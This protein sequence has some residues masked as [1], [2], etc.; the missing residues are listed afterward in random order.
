MKMYRINGLRIPA[1][2]EWRIIGAKVEEQGC[3][4][5]MQSS[6]SGMFEMMTSPGYWKWQSS[7]YDHGLYVDNEKTLKNFLIDFRE[8]K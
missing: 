1:E 8:R 5:C 3:D 6:T 7:G 2:D 4:D